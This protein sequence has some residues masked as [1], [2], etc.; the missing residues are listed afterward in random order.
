MLRFFIPLIVSFYAVQF[1][2]A[3]Q[4][5]FHTRVTYQVSYSGDS[6][7]L[8]NK[9]EEDCF[10]FLGETSTL[11]ESVNSFDKNSLQKPVLTRIEK[12]VVRLTWAIWKDEKEIRTYDSFSVIRDDKDWRF[13]YKEPLSIFDWTL[14]EE[15]KTIEGFACQKATCEFGGRTWTAWF[16][17]DLPISS[18]PYKFG[19]LPGLI[20]SISDTQGHWQFKIKEIERFEENNIS[21]PMNFFSSYKET[22]KKKYFEDQH[23]Y[24]TNYLE[25]EEAKGINFI[26]PEN[27]A[28]I[29]ENVELGFKQS[30]NWIELY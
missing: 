11:S 12:G 22:N 5:S 8:E 30:S 20:V 21:V 25:L 13:V 10:L 15:T 29:K 3:Q 1:S 6:T 18:G 28:I 2:Y 4:S 19:G 26:N 16:S 17:A 27:R 9:T 7:N 24:R 23:Y 14:M